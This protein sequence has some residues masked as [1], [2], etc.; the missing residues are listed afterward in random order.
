VIDYAIL[1]D[2]AARSGPP[3]A[4]AGLRLVFAAEALTVFAGP[5]TPITRMGEAGIILG[6]VFPVGMAE[7]ATG[8]LPAGM[9]AEVLASDGGLL[10]DSLWGGY[11]AAWIG[12]QRDGVLVLRDPSGAAPAYRIEEGSTSRWTSAFRGLFWIG[13]RSAN[14][15]PI[16]MCGTRGP[17]FEASRSFCPGVYFQLR[18]TSAHRSA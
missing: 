3:P 9:S 18:P 7:R 15:P 5:S 12:P 6:T 14:L 17:V 13:A 4:P 10:L 2:P 8:D 11:V 16:R 1:I